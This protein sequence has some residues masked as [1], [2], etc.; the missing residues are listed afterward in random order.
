[1][2]PF[3]QLAA[4]APSPSLFDGHNPS[5]T[6]P[7]FA[8]L[9]L[10]ISVL[11]RNKSAAPKLQQAQKMSIVEQTPHGNIVSN[12]TQASDSTKTATPRRIFS[13]VAYFLMKSW[14]EE[15]ILLAKAKVKLLLCIFDTILIF[16]GVW[17]TPPH[18]EDKLNQAFRDHQ[19]VILIFSVNSSKAFQG[20]AFISCEARHDSQPIDLILPPGKSNRNFSDDIYIRWETCIGRDGQEI[21]PRCAEAL[22][23]LFPSDPTIDIISVTTEV[24]N[25]KKHNSSRSQSH[26]PFPINVSSSSPLETS[27]ASL[28]II[29]GQTLKDRNHRSLP[30]HRHRPMS[31]DFSS[32]HSSNRYR[33]R[34]PSNHNRH[35]HQKSRSRERENQD[36][37]QKRRRSRSSHSDHGRKN[38]SNRKHLHCSNDDEVSYNNTYKT[39]T[40]IT[41]E[42]YE[43]YMTHL[44]LTHTQYAGY[45]TAMFPSG[46]SF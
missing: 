40:E 17:S 44:I 39:I 41:S 24:K 3:G 1:M 35:R 21:E 46:V 15:N 23:R 2:V 18:N 6:P 9:S 16:K 7:K 26:L 8:S 33:H 38:S 5:S 45:G 30:N 22:C 19:Y 12:F 20:F 25:N 43:K 27:P 37:R 36:L 32:R 31:S 11:V 28:L 14:N 34:S 13:D 29:K 10:N 42:T 4:A